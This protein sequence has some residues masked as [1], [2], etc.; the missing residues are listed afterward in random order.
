MFQS[1]QIKAS[2]KGAFFMNTV[3]LQGKFARCGCERNLIAG[4]WAALS[5]TAFI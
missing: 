1:N 2:G 3:Y 4:D 5:Q